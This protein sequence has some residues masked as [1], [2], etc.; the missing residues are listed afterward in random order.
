M[1]ENR[2]KAK[3]LH[4]SLLREEFRKAIEQTCGN[5]SEAMKIVNLSRRTYYKYLNQ[6]NFTYR[7]TV[8]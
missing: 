7:M 2:R 8:E 6:F 5:H 3:E 1:N 4:D